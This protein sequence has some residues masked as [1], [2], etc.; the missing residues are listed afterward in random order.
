VED[1]SVSGCIVFDEVGILRTDE[2]FERQSDAGHHVGISAL[3]RI[4]VGCVSQFVLD[5]MHLVCLGIVRR[6]VFA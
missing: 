6:M 5:Y 4:V 1:E 2:S 3:L